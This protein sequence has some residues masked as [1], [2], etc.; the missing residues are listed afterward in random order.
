MAG[1]SLRKSECVVEDVAECEPVSADEIPCYQEKIQG[2]S[3][4][5][6]P[7]QAS[8]MIKICQ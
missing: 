2:I 8:L 1:K 3:T 5:L 4:L 7:I 6:D